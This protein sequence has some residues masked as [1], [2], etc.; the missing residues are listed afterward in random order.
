MDWPQNWT[1]SQL[2]F[3]QFNS[4]RP[5]FRKFRLLHI[6]L[7]GNFSNKFTRGSLNHVPVSFFEV[8]SVKPLPLHFYI[9][10]SICPLLLGNVRITFEFKR[11]EFKF[12]LVDD[13]SH[14]FTAEL[15]RFKRCFILVNVSWA[16][17][18]LH[19]N[20]LSPRSP[21]VIRNYIVRHAP[22]WKVRIICTYTRRT[23]SNR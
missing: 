21:M 9:V 13:D 18:Y 3:I 16:N 11:L 8:L 1:V 17:E 12:F 10:T 20:E 5:R 4:A 23:F 2:R 19:R 15:F 14:G 6:F 7:F 22:D